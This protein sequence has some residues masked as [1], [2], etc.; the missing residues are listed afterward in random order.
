MNQ[1]TD[2]S[3]SGNP[4]PEKG[5][6]PALLVID[7]QNIYLRTVAPRD[8][9]ISFFFINLLI[10]LFRKNGFPVIRIYN[11][12]PEKGP[13]P[14]S[15][16]FEYPASIKISQED[17]QVIKTYSD[18]FNKTGLDSILKENGSNALFLCG[19]S[20]VGC[21]ISTFVGARNNDYKVF[22]AKDAIM[23]HN[24]EYTRN[25]EIMFGAV[26]YDMIRLIVENS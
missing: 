1:M 18:A 22:L 4:Q 16:E 26:S 3:I 23:S 11:H 10:D 6:R 13:E 25:I 14:G 15:E 20:A 5:I 24:T 19:L 9:E 8:R 17:A 7:T 21:V 12:D 2:K